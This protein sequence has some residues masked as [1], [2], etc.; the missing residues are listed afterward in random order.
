M[1]EIETLDI[2]QSHSAPA[3]MAQEQRRQQ[4]NG[5]RPSTWGRKTAAPSGLVLLT[6]AF[7]RFAS[8]ASGFNPAPAPG[9]EPRL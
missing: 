4:A 8:L 7:R 9:Y 6:I 1:S 2:F 3:F 5:E